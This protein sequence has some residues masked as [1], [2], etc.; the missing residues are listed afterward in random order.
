METEESSGNLEKGKNFLPTVGS[1]CM[2]KAYVEFKATNGF[3]CLN[4]QLY[5]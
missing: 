3:V 1:N 5:K 4:F 2:C